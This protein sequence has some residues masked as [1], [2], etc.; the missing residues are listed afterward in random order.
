MGK[1]TGGWWVPAMRSI[2]LPPRNL[3]LER[4]SELTVGDVYGIATL[5]VKCRVVDVDAEESVWNRLLRKHIL[6][7]TES[8]EQDEGA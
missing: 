8:C 4:V 3:P 6:T 1:Q 5:S 2:Q 7:A